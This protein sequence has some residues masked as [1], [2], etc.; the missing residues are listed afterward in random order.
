MGSVV[1]RR[2]EKPNDGRL[3]RDILHEVLLRL[4][5]DALCRAR[6]VC[7][8]WRSLTSDLSFT[9]AYSSRYHLVAALHAEWDEVHIADL[10]GNIIKRIPISSSC[11][12]D[13]LSTHLDT[14]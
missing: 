1:L 13:D 8:S 11:S 9:E 4:P 14:I 5:P 3:P 12:N 2:K 7:R 10:S 6:L